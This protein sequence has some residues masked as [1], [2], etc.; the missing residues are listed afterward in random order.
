MTTQCPLLAQNGHS[1]RVGECLLLG[2][3]RTLPISR[4]P[5]PVSQLD[6]L[7]CR[8]AGADNETA[9]IHHIRWWRGE[10]AACGSRSARLRRIGVLMGWP[11]SYHQAQSWVAALRD[12]LQKL[13]WTEGRNIAID[14]RWA[15]ADVESMK[16]FAKE[17]VALQPDLIVTG[18]TPATA[19]MLQQTHTIPVIFVEVGDPI[20]SGFVTSL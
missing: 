20:G 10:L 14:T 13:G 16:R 11:E 4:P 7:R 19:A 3:K 8:F 5:L 17:L 2:V 18:S 12:E 1:N 6:P 9:R 15:A